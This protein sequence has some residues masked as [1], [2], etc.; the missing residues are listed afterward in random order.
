MDSLARIFLRGSGVRLQTV[1]RADYH[2]A[3]LR[4]LYALS[5]VLT[6][7]RWDAF[8]I[9]ADTTALVHVFQD[10]RT[11]APVGF[12][13]WRVVAMELPRSYAILGGKLRVHPDFRRRGLHILS[14]LLFY[15]RCKARHPGARFYRLSAAALFGFVSIVQPLAWYR[16]F[17]ETDRSPAGLALA[18]AFQIFAD[19]NGFA[20][21]AGGLVHTDVGVAET[22]LA[23]FGPAYF[24]RDAA[25][26][27]L[28][29][30]PDF[31]RNRCSV[32]F[33]FRFDRRNLVAMTKSVL[34]RR[35]A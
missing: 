17:D 27:Y 1:R 26:A 18:R 19:D 12:Q 21:R 32:A 14:A 11:G 31:R 34:R 23:Q 33:W 13:F 22:V 35:H 9:H 7:E 8:R 5:S 15:L 30:N 10:V 16:F 24:E 4:D 6:D 2:D 28:A 29:R 20:M 25:R 3:F